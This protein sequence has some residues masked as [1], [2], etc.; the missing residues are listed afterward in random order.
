MWPAGNV[1]LA[2]LGLHGLNL[3]CSHP[4]VQAKHPVA[5]LCVDKLACVV[6]CIALIVYW[7]HGCILL[8]VIRAYFGLQLASWLIPR[9]VKTSS[10][11]SRLSSD[12]VRFRPRAQ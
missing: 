11:T 5:I 4:D 2:E 3:G 12:V 1:G 10:P 7:P 8:R 6:Q 9:M